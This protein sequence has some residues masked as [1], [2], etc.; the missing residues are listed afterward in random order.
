[1]PI[2]NLHKVTIGPINIKLVLRIRKEAFLV[3]FAWNH[4]LLL[5]LCFLR[6]HFFD[7][8]LFLF[9][10]EHLSQLF[11]V[12]FNACEVLFLKILKDCFADIGWL[13]RLP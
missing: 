4:I 5:F 11:K 7:L 10:T 9:L 12:Y 2:D 8:F 1:M 13:D 3:P 6:F